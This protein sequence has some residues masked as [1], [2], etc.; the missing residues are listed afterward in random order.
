MARED[1][2]VIMIL[3]M[4]RLARLFG[5]YF[6]AKDQSGIDSDKLDNQTDNTVF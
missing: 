6:L 5:D 2:K 3:T 1:I 4:I